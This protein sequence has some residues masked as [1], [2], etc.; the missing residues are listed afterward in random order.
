MSSA[1]TETSRE[2]LLFHR[3]LLDVPWPRDALF[4]AD[5]NLPVAILD[6]LPADALIRVDAGE[7]LKRLTRIEQLA[8]EVLSRRATRPLTIVAV[9]GGSLGDAVGFLAS[10]LWRGVDLWHVPTTLLAMVDSAHGGKTAV[11]LGAAKNQLGTFYPA[12]AIV[13]CEQVLGN[14]PLTQRRHG[15]TELIKGLWLGDAEL[16]NEVDGCME[17]AAFASFDVVCDELMKW[18]EHAIEVKREVVRR[19][20]F[21]TLGIRTQLNFGH[22]AA[23]ALELELG[24]P[25][26][27]AVAWGMAA[28]AQLSVSH[29]ALPAVQRDRLLTHL[30]PLLEPLA[31]H[32]Q[33]ISR[34]RF[35]ELIGRDKKRVNGLLRSVLLNAPGQAEV[36]THITPELWYESLCAVYDARHGA[37]H[38]ISWC[39]PC[40]HE[41]R[42]SASKSELN[43]AL[44]IKAL[45]PGETLLT[46]ESRADDVER[47]RVALDVLAH[48]PS[49]EPCTVDAGLGGTTLR[50]LMV[51]ALTRQKAVTIKASPRLLERPH[52]ALI[53][54]MESL[55]ASCTKTREALVVI[56]PDVLAQEFEADISVSAS[57]QYASALAMLAA[58]GRTVTLNLKTNDVGGFDHERVVSWL[59]MQMTLDML[60]EVGVR[61]DVDMQH[62]RVHLCSEPDARHESRDLTAHPDESSAALWRVAAFLGAPVSVEGLPEVSRQVDRVLV[63]ILEQLDAIRDEDT[64]LEVDL[65]QSPDLAPVLSAA[66]VHIN[67]GLRITNATHLRLKESNRIEDLVTAY[68]A[69]GISVEAHD[70]G[71]LVP[72]GTQHANSTGVWPT[73]HDHRLAMTA[74][75]CALHTPVRVQAPWVVTKSY[76]ELLADMRQA[77]ATITWEL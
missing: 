45:R 60:K 27:V 71:I 51:A 8:D 2:E 65:G 24:A 39:A 5:A 63:E 4:V 7:S 1:R 49:E 18:L 54:A 3:T 14:L 30:E 75:V 58:S 21:E 70:D 22:T 67:A 47:L 52:D 77:G 34:S 11:N 44:L 43:R 57:S 12:H 26:G 13:I 32:P 19:D 36:V 6:A 38:R 62:G 16:L 28:A 25:H 17:A 72:V 33:D 53:E 29:A 15:L 76:P 31:R 66:A 74:M 61:V 59:Y 23:H 55:G 50:F 46:G 73:Y 56:P 42:L 20:P 48:T 37:V 9:G 69:V 64:I 10:I 35:V 40:I 41:V 68:A